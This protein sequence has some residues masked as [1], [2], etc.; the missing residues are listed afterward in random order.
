[1]KGGETQVS[2]SVPSAGMKE[3]R[4][5]R[6]TE[7]KAERRELWTGALTQL[8]APL[9]PPPHAYTS[10]P[11]LVSSFLTN[12]GD[13]ALSEE[14]QQEAKQHLKAVPGAGG[15]KGLWLYPGLLLER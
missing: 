13:T 12:R 10:R 9:I 6:R 15:G 4:E 8:T 2:K 3:E 5:W 7:S 14:G 1:M 11:A